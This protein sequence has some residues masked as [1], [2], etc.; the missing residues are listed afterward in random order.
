[1]SHTDFLSYIHII[2]ITTQNSLCTWAGTKSAVLMLFCSAGTALNGSATLDPYKGLLPNIV[3]YLLHI[4]ILMNLKMF[5]CS[6]C[7]KMSFA[8]VVLSL[9]QL[10]KR[11]LLKTTMT[12]GMC[13]GHRNGHVPSVRINWILF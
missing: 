2:Y 6:I 9:H 8:C 10:S 11:F 13:T 7:M 1:M 4:D 5:L 3:I 12:K